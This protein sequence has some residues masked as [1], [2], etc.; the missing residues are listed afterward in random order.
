MEKSLSQRFK[1]I[2]PRLFL[3]VLLGA[4]IYYHGLFLPFFMALALVYFI[5]PSLKKWQIR[6]KNWELTV[7]LFLATI[8]LGLIIFLAL[9]TSFVLR[10]LDRFNSSFELLWD[11]NEVQLDQGASKVKDWI[12]EIYNAE[13]LEQ[14]IEKQIKSLTENQDSSEAEKAF[15][16]SNIGESF[17]KLKGFFSSSEPQKEK[18]F[19]FPKF[20]FWYQLGSFLLY[21]VMCLFYYEYFK[22]LRDRY[23]NPKVSDS[24][25]LFWLDFDQSF[26]RFFR[27]RTKIILWQLPLFIVCFLLL[28]LPG[29]FIYLFLIFV[30]LY[31][32]YLHYILLIPMAISALV[33]STEIELSYWWIMGLILAAFILNSILEEALLNPKIMEENI[34][35]NPVLMILGLSFW[36]YALGFWGVM[37]GIPLT[38]LSIIYMKRF[39]APIW[40]EST[41]RV[42]N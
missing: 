5:G 11:Q 18:N 14:Q 24:L 40:L 32:P 21:F 9:G 34:G 39:I 38:S 10:D 26:V 36:S 4:M 15:D 6:L 16:F 31:I 35:L 8:I 20:G 7:S 1:N 30:L 12:N 33:L 2:Y 17:D 19:E 27:L 29:T 42:E 25:K 23:A 41:E 37:L 13:E 3:L 28:D 22:G